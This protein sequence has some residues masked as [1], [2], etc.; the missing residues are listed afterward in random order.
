MIVK[1]L[2]ESIAQSFP[3]IAKKQIILDLDT[4]QK[5]FALESKFLR[6]TGSLSSLSTNT[7]WVLPTDFIEL[8]DVL[9]YD[10]NDNPVFLSDEDLT[11]EI[12][13]GK[14]FIYSLTSTPITGVPTGISTILLQYIYKP[15]TLT[16]ET[17]SLTIDEEFSEALEAKVLSKYFAKFPMDIMDRDGNVNKVFN[18]NAS[19]YWNTQYLVYIINA[20]KKRNSMDKRG[21]SDQGAQQY[22]IPGRFELP[23]RIKDS[24]SSTVII[25][26]ITATYT[27]YLRLR[28]TNPSTVT[29]L[30]TPIGY[31]ITS[32]VY[33]GTTLTINAPSGTF[34]LTD[35]MVNSSDPDYVRTT[36]TTSQIVIDWAEAGT[37]TIEVY[38]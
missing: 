12:A 13:L 35:T 3:Q 8:V 14:F 2:V 28:V 18:L 4:A 9:C 31:T 36:L 34:S 37:R 11:Y 6:K 1:Q 17:D 33:D 25:G 30:Q 26:G 32:Y 5:N 38:E 7:G 22:D 15:S 24:T 27:K 10:A 19:S 29:E 23:R 20:K 21:E 16:V